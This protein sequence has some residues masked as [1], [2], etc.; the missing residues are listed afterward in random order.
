[1][2]AGWPALTL[3]LVLMVLANFAPVRAQDTSAQ[4]DTLNQAEP[5][6]LVEDVTEAETGNGLTRLVGHMHPAL[7]HFPI[8]WLVMTLIVD[9]VT[10][11]GHRPRWKNAGLLLLIAAVLSFIPAIATGLLNASLESDTDQMSLILL[12]RNL[13]FAMSALTIIALGI[14]AVARNELAGTA[15]SL[16]MGLMIAA[17]VLILYAG[18]IAGKAV[19]GPNYLPF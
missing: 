13:I 1:M 17:T 16:Y 4:A 8:G 18:H 2:R 15:Q 10:F 12:H 3:S 19:Y 9:L 11:V 14:R 6:E 7:V 5:V